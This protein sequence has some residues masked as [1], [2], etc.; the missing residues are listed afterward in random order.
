[1]NQ[2]GCTDVSTEALLLTEPLVDLV[3]LDMEFDANAEFLSPLLSIRNLGNYDLEEFIIELEIVEGTIVQE[4]WEGLLPRNGAMFYQMSTGVFVEDELP[5]F[6]VRLIPP[7]NRADQE[8]TNNELC[9]EIGAVGEEYYIIGP[10]PIPALNEITFSIVNLGDQE[11]S[12]E[13]IDMSGRSFLSR[14]LV[15][16]G[17]LVQEHRLDLNNLANGRYLLR[18]QIGLTQ[19]VYKIQVLRD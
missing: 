7:Q 17:A 3:L 11:L 9:D 19:E 6:C 4:Q 10:S 1:M 12:V 8:P 2:A 16:N 5:F 18:I 14:S 13:L 15:N